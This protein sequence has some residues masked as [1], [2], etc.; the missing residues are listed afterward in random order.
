MFGNVFLLLVF[1]FALLVCAVNTTKHVE[2]LSSFFQTM[3]A[4]RVCKTLIGFV[5]FL[6]ESWCL[7]R[8]KTTSAQ[9][10]IIPNSS[11]MSLRSDANHHCLTHCQLLKVLG[12]MCYVF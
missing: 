7:L 12:L 10:S 2:A 8:S 9:C 1:Y 4:L 3:P 6:R 11:S 5:C